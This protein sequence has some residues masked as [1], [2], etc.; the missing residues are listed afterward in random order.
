M[1][2]VEDKNIY[3]KIFG[4]FLWTTLHNFSYKYE[5]N[6]NYFKN[7]VNIEIFI[8]SIAYVIP[9]SICR[10]HFYH[11]TIIYKNDMNL[12]DYF[13]KIHDSVTKNIL[14]SKL[15]SQEYTRKE[16]QKE[17]NSVILPEKLTYEQTEGFTDKILWN[18]IFLIC[19]GFPSKPDKN[20][21]K[22]Y[23][24]FFNTL[25]IINKIEYK[26]EGIL[27]KTRLFTILYELYVENYNGNVES[28]EE[29]LYKMDDIF[30]PK[31]IL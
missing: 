4:P 31:T 11:R 28:K 12:I 1:F 2:N 30:I 26:I 15:L 19:I 17:I 20:D 6:Y 14:Y 21:I 16:I 10:I 25:F 27:N 22:N 7:K 24:Y 23:T 9:C 5:N 29:I 13:I 3:P 18:T 8:D